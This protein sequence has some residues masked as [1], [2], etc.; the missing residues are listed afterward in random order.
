[1]KTLITPTLAEYQRIV[2]VAVSNNFNC[3]DAEYRQLAQYVRQY[4]QYFFFVNCNVNTPRLL[5]L[6]DHPYRA[7]ITVNPNLI[8]RE[9]E[10]ERLYALRHDV[11]PFVRV[12]YIPESSP[13]TDLI[14]ELSEEGYEVVVTNQRFNGKV[15]LDKYASRGHYEFSCNRYRLHTEAV[16]K[17]LKIIDRT[18]RA[19]LCDRKGI[20]CAGCGMC[21]TLTVGKS[22]PLYSLNLSTSGECKFSCPDCYAHTIQ[23]FLRGCGMPIIRYDTIMRNSKQSGRTKHIKENMLALSLQS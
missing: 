16:K 22:L 17:L 12:K 11:V 23:R 9:R 14:R 15:G 8:V 6:N 7:V 13:I 19:H 3:T 21:S 18:P 10:I 4:P 1:M 2:R 5:T 20:G